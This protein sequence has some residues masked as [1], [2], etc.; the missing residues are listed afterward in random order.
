MHKQTFECRDKQTW[1][2]MRPMEV[3]CLVFA[4]LNEGESLM[5]VRKVLNIDIDFQ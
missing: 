5:G 4:F 1:G 2:E 3:V